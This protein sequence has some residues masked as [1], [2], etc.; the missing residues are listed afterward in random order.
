VRI[1]LVNILFFLQLLSFAQIDLTDSLKQIINTI[2]PNCKEPCKK[3]TLKVNALNYMVQL[4]ANSDP[5]EALQYGKKALQLAETLNW[6]KG[7]GDSYNSVGSCYYLLSDYS[8]TLNHWMRALKIREELKDRM[9]L[10]VTYGN[11][12]L[13]H[14]EIA[15]YS[16]S[17]EYQLKAL[18][19][20]EELGNKEGITRHFTNLGA[21]YASQNNYKKGEEYYLQALKI[22]EE[23]NNIQNQ[24]VILTNLGLN[25]SDQG[26]HKK[27]LECFF[28]SLKLP[29]TENNKNYLAA[30]YGNI[31][32]AY[33]GIKDYT[34]ALNYY[35]KA[36]GINKEIGRKS[37]ISIQNGNIGSLY[38]ELGKHNE[39]EKF[40]KAS[41][42]LADSIGAQDDI[43]TAQFNLTNLYSKTGDYK[44][45]FFHYKEYINVRD[46]M[47]NEEREKK[48]LLLETT[49]EFNKKSA[50]LQAQQEKERA[51]T[52]YER[53]KQSTIIAL[54]A[55]VLLLITIFAFNTLRKN[56]FITKQKFIL[57]K[58]NEIIEEKQREITES[59]TYAKRIQQAILPPTELIKQFL[60]DIFIIYKPKDIVAGD[61]YWFYPDLS[62]NTF[63]LAAA[64]CTGHGVPG[65]FTS[66]VC[67]EKLNYAIAE[68]KNCGEILAKTNKAVKTTLRQTSE[69]SGTSRDGMDIALVSISKKGKESIL[70]YAGANRPLWIV[71]NGT[72]DIIEIKATKK[73]IGGFTDENQEFETH[74]ISLS[75]GDIIY[76]FTDGYADQDGG[77]KGKKMMIKN[78]KKVIT[79][80]CHKSMEEQ[81][82][83]L[84]GFAIQWRRN[85]EQ[86]DDILVIGLRV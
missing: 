36:L 83:H 57:E 61:F 49:Y 59:I 63:Y 29:G 3:D 79:E 37:G 19:I 64:D 69:K 40:L 65:A 80:I 10:S 39:S 9:D 18:K 58:K 48:Q 52:E 62:N 76:L 56:K 20:D 38:L 75:K 82:N 31:G 54:I 72:N 1:L 15:N 14:R 28:K 60:P 35:F 55:G 22:A 51:I 23:Q 5:E 33:E 34:T 66:V 77:E 24:A 17:L 12:G 13:V 73:A 25:Y 67:S 50:I 30:T 44:E 71:K 81:K 26:N 84:E 42:A 7:I 41:L 32:M 70:K 8:N 43:K 11:L 4:I 85:K 68:T 6:K 46:E 78:L 74:Q 27:A 21:L 45:A 86:L 16:K 53:K 47:Y 2:T